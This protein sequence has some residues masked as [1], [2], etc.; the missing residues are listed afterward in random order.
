MSFLPIINLPWP[1]TLHAF[2]L[3]FLGLYQTFRLPSS[4]KGISS[5][6]KPVPANPMLGIATFGLSLAYLSTSYM[7]IAQNQFLYATVPV[8]IILACMAAA[9]LVLEGRDGNLS[10]DEKRNLLVVAAYDGLGA[11]AL[12]LW[13]GTFEGRVPGPY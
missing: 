13:L 10:A 11:V 8:R 7:P 2:G 3:A 9:R 1:I 12:G 6:S 5:S 4:T